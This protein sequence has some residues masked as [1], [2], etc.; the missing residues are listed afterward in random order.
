MNLITVHND[1]RPNHAKFPQIS[2][3]QMRAGNAT[4]GERLPRIHIERCAPATNYPSCN[5]IFVQVRRTKLPSE[6]PHIHF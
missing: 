5:V 2:G 6:L 1:A 3:G 4:G